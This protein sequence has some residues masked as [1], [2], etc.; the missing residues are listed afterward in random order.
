MEDELER[1]GGSSES[2]VQLPST[3][4]LELDLHNY[5]YKKKLIIAYNN[6]IG[7]DEPW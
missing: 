1:E 6:Y 7:T 4:Q 2:G 3:S 5:N